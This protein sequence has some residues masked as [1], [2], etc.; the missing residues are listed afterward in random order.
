MVL[1]I[2]RFLDKSLEEFELQWLSR[3]SKTSVL[4]TRVH[5]LAREHITVFITNLIYNL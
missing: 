4:V 1:A 2:L 3:P 5:L